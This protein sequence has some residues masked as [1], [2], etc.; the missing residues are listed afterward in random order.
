MPGQPTLSSSAADAPVRRL[1]VGVIGLGPR[2]RKQYLPAL[3]GLKLH[4]AIQE[5]CDSITYRAE[6]EAR[7]LGCSAAAGPTQLFE[8]TAIDACLLLDSPWYRLWPLEAACRTGKPVL[9][10]SPLALD[11]PHADS[12]RQRV[13]QS[14]LTVMTGLA[15]RL[16][17]PMECVRQLLAN[18]LGPARLV[19]GDVSQRRSR[20]RPDLRP[21]QPASILGSGG[22]ALIDCC[23]SLI[24]GPVQSVLATQAQKA[25]LTTILLELTGGRAVQ[26]V[27]R[28]SKAA[29]ARVHLEIVAERGRATIDFPAAVR[30]INAEGAQR[31]RLRK[32]PPLVRVLLERF[33][34]AVSAG[35][36]PR[37]NLE[38]ADMAL[39]CLRA[40]VRSLNEGRRIGLSST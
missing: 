22:P 7:R 36:S 40:A 10:A 34:E 4:F 39:T 12:L 27:R 28:Q 5:L 29:G 24:D 18:D 11:D 17:A 1:Q 38:D 37:P 30:W 25:G 8:N 9:C 32:P 3:L 26:I 14:R 2:W 19:L 6:S 33:H 31:L 13:Q 21:A 15:L 23:L 35:Q 20:A 16:T